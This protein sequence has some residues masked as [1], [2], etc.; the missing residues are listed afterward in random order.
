MIE[1]P[2]SEPAGGDDANLAVALLVHFGLGLFWLVVL[3]EIGAGL[4]ARVGG[5]VWALCAGTLWIADAGR[6]IAAR[7]QR[8]TV[9]RITFVWWLKSFVAPAFLLLEVVKIG[10]AHV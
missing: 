5:L 9:W 8:G 3:F 1:R 4:G 10:R 6:M 2:A 7:R